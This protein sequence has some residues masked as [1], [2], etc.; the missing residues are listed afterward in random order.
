[1]DEYVAGIIAMACEQVIENIS[2]CHACRQVGAEGKGSHIE[3]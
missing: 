3:A 2:E 1:M